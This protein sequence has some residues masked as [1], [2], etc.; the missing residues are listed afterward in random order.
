MPC[1]P[2]R[3]HTCATIA[4]RP[5]PELHKAMYEDRILHPA[6]AGKIIPATEAATYIKDK[7]VVAAGGFTGAGEAKAVL[8]AL[9]ERARINPMKITLISGASLGHNTDGALAAAHAVSLRL[10][11]QTDPA[12]RAAINNGEL[13]FIDQHLSET[14]NLVNANNIPGIDI[15]I[16]EATLI[17]ADGSIVPST[18]IGNSATFATLADK[19]IIEINLA[20]PLSLYGLHDIFYPGEYPHRREIP[21]THA[22]NRIGDTSISLDPEKILGIVITDI[23]DSPAD[24]TPPTATTNSIST[25]LL[26]FFKNEVARKHLPPSLLPLQAG[27]GKI[28]NAVLQGLADGPFDNLTMYSEILQDSTFDLIDAGKLAAASGSA[29]TLSSACL[30]KVLNNLDQYRD[31]IVLRP[32]DITN[33]GEVI[34]RLGVIAINTA[35]ECDIYGNVNSTHIGGTH[36]MNGIGGSGDFARNAYISIFVTGSIAAGG[37]ISRIVPMVAHVDHTEHDVDV[38]ITEYGLADLRGL[39]PRQRAVCIINNCAHPDYKDEL[40]DY[41]QRAL[42]GGGQTPHLL[43]EALSWHA[44]LKETGT[45]R[46]EVMV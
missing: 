10:P 45:M 31:K 13:N 46:Q 15:A 19:I 27:V 11:F 41:F 3:R 4:F 37:D 44:R 21:V 42:K 40:M 9:A 35:L 32:Q 6:L 25:H 34:R 29:L 24:V 39:A 5:L 30:E 28:A 26:S 17:N 1:N 43:R 12:M 7:M 2:A 23:K 20:A 14:A 16:I 36:M 33:A 38:I 18:S 22:G 8:Q